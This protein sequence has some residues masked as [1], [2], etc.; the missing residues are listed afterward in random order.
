MASSADTA[1]LRFFS[2]PA[3]GDLRRFLTQEANVARGRVIFMV[4]LAGGANALMLALLN[5]AADQVSRSV[6]ESRLFVAYLVAFTL[7]LYTQRLSMG[8]ATA[9]VERTIERVRLRLTDK[10]RRVPL[11]LVEQAGGIGGF[12]AL[13]H[14]TQMIATSGQLVVGTL[15]SLAILSFSLVYLAWLSPLICLTVL[16]AVVSYMVINRWRAG[17]TAGYLQSANAKEGDFL[18]GFGDLLGGFKELQM[19]RS[20]RDALGHRLGALTEQARDLK[21][22]ANERQLFD[23]T[24]G[25]TTLYLLLLVVVFVLPILL[26]GG[27]SKLHQSV[28]TVLYILGPIGVITNALGGLAAIDASVG[29]LYALEAQLDA[30]A[31]LQGPDREVAPARFHKLRLDGL[32]FRY[33]DADAT[34][35]F[36]SGP[37]H[38]D[39]VAG[40]LLF[41]VGGNGTGKSTFLKLLTGLYPGS[42]GRLLCD[43]QVVDAAA[44]EQYR[45]MYAIVFADFHLFPRLYGVSDVADAHVDEWLARLGLAD[46]TRCVAGRFTHTDLSTGQRKRLAFLAAVLEGRPI[47]IFD[48]VASDQ[49]P[50]F[51]RLFYEDILPS[52]KAQ[53]RTVIVVSHDDAYFHVADRILRLDAGA[54]VADERPAHPMPDP[55]AASPP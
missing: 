48:E 25:G 26:P 32:T 42:A 16:A 10:V 21:L 15:G 49:D 1:A 39:I 4:L 45:A 8:E 14:D 50:A 7:F 6:V 37:H 34:T 53:G 19:S 47:C 46:K 2:P 18:R 22:Q 24:F 11:R 41:L 43:E 5:L 31:E 30:A 23:Y 13:I 38:L 51:R 40:E 35:L 33:Q 54:I 9:A 52:L 55:A 44:M 27:D 28:A 17:T 36:T 3:T 20:Q 29:R 12:S